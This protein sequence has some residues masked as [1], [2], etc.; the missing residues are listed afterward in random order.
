MGSELPPFDPEAA[1]SMMLAHGHA[2]WLGLSYRAHGEDWVELDLPWR[3]DLVGEPEHGILA[4]GPIV[5]LMDMASGMAVWNAMGEF[6]AIATLDLRVD[7]MRPASKGAAVT[8]HS[9]CY[10]ITKSAAFVRGFAH[11][12][13][14]DDPVANMAGVFMS[15]PWRPR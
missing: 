8:G 11:D 13:D 4:S 10:K 1:S 7:Y 2:G 5:S 6:R 12:G 14:P 3:D 15:I 9:Q